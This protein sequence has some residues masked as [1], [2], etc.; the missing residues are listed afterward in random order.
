MFDVIGSIVIS[1]GL[2]CLPNDEGIAPPPIFFPRTAPVVNVFVAAVLYED[3]G[4]S[5]SSFIVMP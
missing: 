4:S 1:L 3:D 2:C 5:G